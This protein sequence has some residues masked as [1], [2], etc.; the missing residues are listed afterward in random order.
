[1]IKKKKTTLY[2]AFKILSILSSV[3]E[4]LQNEKR[5]NK[6]GWWGRHRD[7]AKKPNCLTEALNRHCSGRSFVVADDRVLFSNVDMQCIHH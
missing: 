2:S 3:P 5:V 6:G 1:M 4:L 7:P